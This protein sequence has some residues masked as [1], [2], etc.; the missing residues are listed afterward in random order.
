M[1]TALILLFSWNQFLADAFVVKPASRRETWTTFLKEYDAKSKH[2]TFDPFEGYMGVDME[3]AKE[4]ADNF[5]KCSV[6]EMKLIKDNLHKQRLQNFMNGGSGMTKPS[7]DALQHLILEEELDLQLQM[8]KDHTPD[9]SFFPEDSDEM[10]ALPHL[11]DPQPVKHHFG[12][13]P[14][15]ILAIEESV[16]EENA[17]ETAMFCLVMTAFILMPQLLHNL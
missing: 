8:M 6:E 13:S 7:E 2:L 14:V 12:P 17:L 3:R 5:G 1:K 10:A 16:L 15:Q 4:C 11:K 9:T